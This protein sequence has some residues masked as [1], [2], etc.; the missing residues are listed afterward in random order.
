MKSLNDNLRDEFSD[1]LTKP[2][3][4]VIIDSKKLDSTIIQRAFEKLL[5]N[6]MG[7]DESSLIEKGRAEFE[8]FIINA[9]KTKN[10]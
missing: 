4:N 7:A 1:I 10:H 6:K 2:E 5:E 8:T 9:I 3:F